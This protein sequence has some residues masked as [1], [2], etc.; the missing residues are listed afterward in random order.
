[1]KLALTIWRHHSGL[2]GDTSLGVREA[3][4]FFRAE[5]KGEV[6]VPSVISAGGSS[7]QAPL[8][9]ATGSC[10]SSA[11][12]AA[13]KIIKDGSSATDFAGLPFADAAFDA[14]DLG[15]PATEPALDGP[16]DGGEAAVTALRSSME[17]LAGVPWP[18][19]GAFDADLWLPATEPA[20]EASC[21]S[22]SPCGGI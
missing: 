13:A 4:G 11:W 14:A 12:A 8:P 9:C 19:D 3:L 2:R 22:C 10:R 15:L 21:D 5:G 17:A 16:F 20:P 1:M 6:A 7:C 18:D